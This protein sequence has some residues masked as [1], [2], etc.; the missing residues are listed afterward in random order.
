M[1]D[2]FKLGDRSVNRIGYGAMQLAGKGVFGPPRDRDQAIAVVRAAIEA[3]VNHIDT[4]DYYGPY[5][6]NEIIREAL[7]PYPSDLVLVTKIGGRRDDKGAWLPAQ[8]SDELKSAVEDNVKRLGLDVMEVV[9][10][11]IIGAVHAPSEGS[12][13]RQV[14]AM[15]EMKAA[16]RLRH[17]GLSNVTAAQLA[18]AQSIT[19]IV[20]VQ[21]HYNLVQRG[22]DSLV[23]TLAGQTIAF[24]PFFPLGG[25]TP[26]QSASLTEV[27]ARLGA[28]PMQVALAWLRRRAPNILL[29]PG[30]SSIEHLRENLAVAGIDL[31]IEASL[32][33][34]RIGANSI[35]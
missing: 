13:A 28:T 9:N 29:I 4:S 19:E 7:Y 31:P 8:K 18:E 5:V 24:V 12:I 25:F 14:E 15:A 26:L 23:D 22:D 27:A 3:G 10:L 34:D 30:T 21:N 20:C 17:V 6:V 32:A 2:T 16:G 11:R 35:T 33:L 1:N